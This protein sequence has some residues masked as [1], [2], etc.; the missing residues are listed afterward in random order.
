MS[1]DG[2]TDSKR[3]GIERWLNIDSA[4]IEGVLSVYAG[5]PF[6]Y[7]RDSF[8]YELGRQIAVL[9]KT[10]GFKTKGTLVRRKPNSHQMAWVKTKINDIHSIV[11][12]LGH[13]PR[14]LSI[15]SRSV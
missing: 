13:M 5:D 15:P 2:L 1:N 14:S 9:A 4:M 12:E 6:D 10:R 7:T 11:L 3:V 8:A